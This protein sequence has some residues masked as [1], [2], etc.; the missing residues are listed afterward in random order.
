MIDDRRPYRE[1]A[2]ENSGRRRRDPGFLNVDNDVAID[3]VGVDRTIAEADDVEIDRCQ[4]F[5]P[6]LRQNP[7]L[8]ISGERTGARDDRSELFG[9][10]GLEGEPGL[11]CPE[12]AR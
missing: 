1:L 3:L 7:L 12:A 4:Q 6:R 9:A 5:E 10:V 8:Q 11:E 2:I